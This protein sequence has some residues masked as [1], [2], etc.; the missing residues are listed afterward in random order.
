MNYRQLQLLAALDEY[1]NLTRVAEQL[2]VTAPAVSKALRD[3]ERELDADLFRRGARGI[4]P[5]VYG[6]CMI[7]HARTALADL[8]NAR[9]ELRALKSGTLGSVALGALPAAAPLLAPLAIVELKRR[10]PLTAVLLREG[11]IDALM[12]EL[13]LR[14]ID[15]IVGN[16]PPPRLTTGLAV[17]VL[18]DNDPV[19]VVCRTRHPLA[20]R[21]TITWTNLLDYPWIIPP[22]GTSMRKSFE[23]FLT[24]SRHTLAQNCVKSG[25]IVSSKTYI[26]RTDGLGFFSRQIAEHFAEQ[27]AITILK[28]DLGFG[29]GPVGMMH[30]KDHPLS[31]ALELMLDS[32]RLAAKSISQPN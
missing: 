2:H 6:D 29:V 23:S 24:K 10:A 1:R 12:P 13:Q 5:T 19:V 31:P 9:K 20:R 4:T 18:I 14:K 30:R 16:L 11:T 3:I 15:A 26:E 28:F 7:R 17:E 21:R 25:S 27:R 22:S 8:S 32:L